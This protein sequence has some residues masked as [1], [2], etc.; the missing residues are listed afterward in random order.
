MES[1]MRKIV[2]TSILSV[3]ALAGLLGALLVSAEPA[4]AKRMTCLQKYRM[5]DRRCAGANGG[6]GDGWINCHFRTCSP[7]YENCMGTRGLVADKPKNPGA[8]TKG[9]QSQRVTGPFIPKSPKP[10]TGGFVPK[11]RNPTGGIVPSGQGQRFG[12]QRMG[13]R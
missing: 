1:K 9:P 6:L 8:T 2:S 13:R 5:C 12:G 4:E 10:P 11:D 3:G 7:Q